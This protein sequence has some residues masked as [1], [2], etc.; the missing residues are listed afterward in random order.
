MARWS[1]RLTGLDVPQLL[2]ASHIKPWAACLSDDERLDA[3]NGLTPH[4]DALFDGGWMTVEADGQ[5]LWSP[6]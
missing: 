4:L 2:R 5:I 3:F 6:A 1:C